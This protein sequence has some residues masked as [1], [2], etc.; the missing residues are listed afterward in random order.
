MTAITE[1]GERISRVESRIDDLSDRTGRLEGAYQHLATKA[2]IG[3]LKSDIAEL[4]SWVLWRVLIGAAAIQGLVAAA[5]KYL[6]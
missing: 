5:I 4:K 1:H 2:D 3:L 6:P